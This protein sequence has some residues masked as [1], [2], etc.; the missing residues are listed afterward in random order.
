[1]QKLTG[2]PVPPMEFLKRWSQHSLELFWGWPD[3]QRQLVLATSAAEFFVWLVGAVDES[4]GRE[5]GNL[6]ATLHRAGVEKRRI[7]SLGYF[8]AIAGQETTT[9]LIQTAVFGALADGRWDSCADPQTGGQASKDVVRE[10]L[11][12]ASSVP[13]WRRITAVDAEVGGESFR[14][15]DE[16]VLRL[17]GGMPGSPDDDS[18]AFGYGIHRCLGAGI[19]RLETELVLSATARA[20]PGIE[21]LDR[22]P[23]WNHLLSFQTPADVKTRL[24]DG[25]PMP[26]S[27]KGHAK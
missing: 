23:R 21:L 12:R 24:Q 4:V 15:G 8:L 13:T 18:L 17:S 11:A 20:L 25:A 9:M 22:E 27:Q 26:R 6:Y 7:V 2:I 3:E 1:M 14:A 19:A 5:D 16:L 10:A